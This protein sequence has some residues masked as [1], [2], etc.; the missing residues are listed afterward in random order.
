MTLRLVTVSA[1]TKSKPSGSTRLLQPTFGAMI[2]K[3]EFQPE[4]ER[5]LARS[6]A[7]DK[8]SPKRYSIASP[9][10]PD[11]EFV[12]DIVEEADD[13]I[14]RFAT[15]DDAR[16]DVQNSQVMSFLSRAPP[17]PVNTSFCLPN[18]S[19]FGPSLLSRHSASCRAST[20]KSPP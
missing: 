15:D 7:D 3:E 16:A 11:E 6:F 10:L 8:N 2:P 17:S 14:V 9:P 13:G 19:S 18:L 1:G 5:E 4:M 12:A 20:I